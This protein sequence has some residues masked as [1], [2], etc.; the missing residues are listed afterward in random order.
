MFSS[1]SL[2]DAGRE[3]GLPDGE[4]IEV[5]A[6]QWLVIDIADGRVAFDLWQGSVHR[7]QAM[8]VASILL[9]QEVFPFN[10]RVSPDG[11]VVFDSSPDRRFVDSYAL[12]VVSVFP[13]PAIE[14][15]G[16]RTERLDHEFQDHGEMAIALFPFASMS[17]VLRT[18]S[19]DMPIPEV[20]GIVDMFDCLIS[21]ATT[22]T[23]QLLPQIIPTAAGL[24][25]LRGYVR[26]LGISESFADQLTPLTWTFDFY[27]SVASTEPMGSQVA[28]LTTPQQN[29]A[30]DYSLFET[31]SAELYY[32]PGSL[33][34]A[35]QFSWWSIPHSDGQRGEWD[36]Y[37][38]IEYLEYH[39]VR[40]VFIAGELKPG[41][42]SARGVERVGVPV[43]VKLAGTRD[44][45]YRDEWVPNHNPGVLALLPLP[46]YSDVID[47]LGSEL[48][49]AELKGVV[50]QFDCVV[51]R[52]DVHAESCIVTLLPRKYPTKTGLRVMRSY[53]L[54]I[55]ATEASVQ[56]ITQLRWPLE[57]T[58]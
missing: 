29:A 14:T 37:R 36:L 35:G 25:T 16:R 8:G 9:D 50:D 12:D 57:F 47:C 11:G 51:A 58:R 46:S 42:I 26:T 49:R 54:A 28:V 40:P 30:T 2:V 15:R 56:S 39:Q 48:P 43:E 13:A 5:E 34:D 52:V 6:F 44:D 55:G 27:D 21:S 45:G 18:L 41:Y 38:N 53:L 4:L 10:G 20:S 7:L 24:E 17:A 33:V 32:P 31:V 3:V 23:V 1:V 19:L 22:R